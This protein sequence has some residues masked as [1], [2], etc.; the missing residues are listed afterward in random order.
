[1]VFALALTLAPPAL[2][3]GL[4]LLVGLASERARRV[5]HLGLVAILGAAIALQVFDPRSSAIG[6]VLALA[7]GAGA[8]AAYLRLPA[9]RS[10]LSVLAPAP[11]VFL[12]LFLGLS[13]VSKLIFSS[14]VEAHAVSVSSRAP[15]VVLVLDEL[16][17]TSL[18]DA[19]RHVDGRNYPNFARLAGDARA[20]TS[21]RSRPTTRRPS[22]ASSVATTRC[23]SRRRPP[24]SARAR[25]AARAGPPSGGG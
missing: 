14:D 7:V 10:F 5:L 25:S 1:V 12:V 2:A 15:V 23:T 3:Y 16:P 19:T 20:R 18:L 9:A 8:A 6:L 22:S 13:D 17:L 24:P 21:C 11:L 4:E